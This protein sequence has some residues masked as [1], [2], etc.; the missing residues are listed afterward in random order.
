MRKKLI[1][2]YIVLV[3]ACLFM[4]FPYIWMVITSFKTMGEISALPPTFFPRNSTLGNYKILFTKLPYTR[5]LLNTIFSTIARITAQ[6]LLCS[7]AAYAFAKIKFPGKKIIFTL[8][9]SVMMVPG[10]I[11][12]IPQ[13][14]IIA[15][16][17]MTNSM[18]A[19]IITALAS[20]FGIFLLR[21]FFTTL[22]DELIESAKIDGCTHPRIFFS[23]A[24]PLV[25]PALVTLGI[26]VIL[27]TW[28]D[29]MW[30]LIVN[31][32]LERMPLSAGLAI[33]AFGEYGTQNNI[34]MA[35][36]T[37]ATIP[38]LIVFITLQ[39]YYVEGIKLSGLK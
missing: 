24:L 12:M 9:L 13:Y 15:A 23:I 38:I 35:G 7:M 3:L 34:L 14:K 18:G 26:F 2:V 29:L 27:W 22:P 33:L 16:L 4:I 8:I 31:T 36:A 10:Q 1:P 39:K 32:S 6:I 5:L 19:L 25:G 30:P 17:K 20:A 21:Q 37:A 11:H 28:N